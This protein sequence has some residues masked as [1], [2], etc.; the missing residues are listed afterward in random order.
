MKK[1]LISV[2]V[3]ATLG[4]AASNAS[5]V[6]LTFTTNVEAGNAAFPSADPLNNAPFG[7][8]IGSADPDFRVMNEGTVSGG[9]EKQIGPGVS[10][11]FDDISNNLTSVAGTDT[12]PGAAAYVTNDGVASAA[13]GGDTGLFQNALFLGSPFGFL[14]PTVGSA[15]GTAYGAGSISGDTDG[16][17]AF[18]V[19]FPVL[20]AQ[21]NGGPF[22]I[23]LNSGGITFNCSATAG[24]FGCQAEEQIA[25]LDDSLGF[26]GQYT[27]WDLTGTMPETGGPEPIPVPAAVWLFGSGLMGMVGVARRKKK[28]A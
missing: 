18:S 15:A 27:Q 24:V 14:A 20:E 21:W 8:L 17:G 23:G 28:S 10:W 9:G 1:S 22:T 4:V 3:A 5:A 25:S 13:P 6:T 12:T 19:F 7:T 26:A 2:A 11:T 16:N